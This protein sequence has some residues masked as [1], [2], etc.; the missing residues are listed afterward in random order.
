MI[1]YLQFEH[2]SVDIFKSME[3]ASM[4]CTKKFN[5]HFKFTSNIEMEAGCVSWCVQYQNFN[6][7]RK[8]GDLTE[9]RE[10]D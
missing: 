9:M 3:N 4:H 10:V 5:E 7:Q 1:N 2:F 8:G 6:L